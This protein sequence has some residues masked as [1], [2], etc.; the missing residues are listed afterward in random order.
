MGWQGNTDLVQEVVHWLWNLMDM[1]QIFWGFTT[2]DILTILFIAEEISFK[3]LQSL[4][5]YRK[6]H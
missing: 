5:L 6:D 4:M 3:D 1:T 2:F